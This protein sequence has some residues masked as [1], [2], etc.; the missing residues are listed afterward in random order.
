MKIKWLKGD[1]NS[2]FFHRWASYRRS[3]SYIS[4]LISNEGVLLSKKEDIEEEIISYYQKLY[5]SNGS[6]CVL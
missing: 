4:S 6:S 3:R 2:K 5:S 1:V